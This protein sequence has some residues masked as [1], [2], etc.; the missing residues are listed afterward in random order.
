MI[1]KFKAYMIRKK[2][3]IDKMTTMHSVEDI[4]EKR[5]QLHQEFL[6]IDLTEGNSLRQKFWTEA[7]NWVLKD[8]E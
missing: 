6:K 2:Y 4:I 7:L 1:K 8:D 5:N 3:L